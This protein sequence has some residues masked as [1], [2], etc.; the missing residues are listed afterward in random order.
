LTCYLL[1]DSLDFKALDTS[2]MR[3]LACLILCFAPLAI[4]G[5]GQSVQPVPGKVTLFYFHADWCAPCKPMSR[6]LDQMAATDADIALRKVDVTNPG[7]A[8]ENNIQAVPHVMVYN[9]GG[10]LVGTVVG[11]DVEKVK[12]YVAQAKSS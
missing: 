11:L 6:A 10:S 12:S 2:K 5:G 8:E 7:A 3:S 1:P 4:A 9:R